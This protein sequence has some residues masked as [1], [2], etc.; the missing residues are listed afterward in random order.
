MSCCCVLCGGD[1][2]ANSMPACLQAFACFVPLLTCNWRSI[3]NESVHADCIKVPCAS[4]YLLDILH[5]I[6]KVCNIL[7]ACMHTLRTSRDWC[8]CILN[9]APTLF[10][11]LYSRLR[12]FSINDLFYKTLLQPLKILKCL[13]ML[14]ASKQ[15]L[16]KVFDEKNRLV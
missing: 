6:V 13:E 15:K 1:D 16:L 12:F 10:Y 11:L 9:F 5:S 14:T 7:D 4:I 3:G 8:A 2:A